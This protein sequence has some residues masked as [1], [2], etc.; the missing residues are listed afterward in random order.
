MPISES[1][2][3]KLILYFPYEKGTNLFD[4][5]ISDAL[6]T[7]EYDTEVGYLPTESTIGAIYFD[8]KT[9]WPETFYVE[10][11]ANLKTDAGFK[12]TLT[13]NEEVK[14]MVTFSK[15]KHFYLDLQ[16]RVDIENYK[17]MKAGE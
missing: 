8:K 2:L 10:L 7:G 1:M 14:T 13:I 6:C 12:H 9:P 15:L 3:P 5:T 11:T 17:I 4:V 16:G